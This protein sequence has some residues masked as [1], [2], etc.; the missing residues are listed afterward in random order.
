MSY[1]PGQSNHVGLQP[2][3][4]FVVRLVLPSCTTT[5]EREK[6]YSTTKGGDIGLFITL[7]P[8]VL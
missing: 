3:E 7:V 4:P 2:L 5:P 1:T 8:K 6:V